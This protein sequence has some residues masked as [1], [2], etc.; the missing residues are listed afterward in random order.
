MSKNPQVFVRVDAATKARIE[1]ESTLTGL[2]QRAVIAKL[3]EKLIN[4]TPAERSAFLLRRA[5]SE[6]EQGNTDE[7]K[8]LTDLA[9]NPPTE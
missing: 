7:A 2:S 3:A 5:A 6:L 1:A 8:R 4:Q 9:L